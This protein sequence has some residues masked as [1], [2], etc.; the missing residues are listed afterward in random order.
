MTDKKQ[1]VQRGIEVHNGSVVAGDQVILNLGDRPDPSQ[2]EM[3]RLVDRYKKEMEQGLEFRGVVEK[4]QHFIFS[5]DGDEVIGLKE[6]LK[7]ANLDSMYDYAEQA[8]EIFVKKL[9]K[10]SMSEVAQEMIA[11]LL[12]QMWSD[13]HKYVFPRIRDGTSEAVANKLVDEH[14][15][16][17]VKELFSENVLNL[18]KDEIDGMLY[19]L[20][21]NCY[22]KWIK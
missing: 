19:F 17:P 11:V 8:K 1:V 9:V 3:K 7:N 16:R 18:Y 10:H 21:G 12:V 15:V 5:A 6:K 22:V 13:F 14:V 4:L 2:S 20:T